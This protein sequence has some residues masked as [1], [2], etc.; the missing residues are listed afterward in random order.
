MSR[1][2]IG[3]VRAR[4]IPDPKEY[5]VSGVL[6]YKGRCVTGENGAN[7]PALGVDCWLYDFPGEVGTV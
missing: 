3:S 4:E 1:S 6:W 2:V 7:M 5:K